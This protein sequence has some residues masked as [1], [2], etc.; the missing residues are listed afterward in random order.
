MDTSQLQVRKTERE[1]YVVLM[2]QVIE[3]IF[4]FYFV[5]YKLKMVQLCGIEIKLPMCTNISCD[6]ESGFLLFKV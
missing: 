5:L 1:L 6:T 2:V 3:N 4:F